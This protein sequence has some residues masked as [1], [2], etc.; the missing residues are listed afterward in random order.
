MIKFLS[1]FELYWAPSESVLGVQGVQGPRDVGH[2]VRQPGDP[3]Q[4]GGGEAAR[5]ELRRNQRRGVVSAGAVAAAR[6][7]AEAHRGG[8]PGQQP[9]DM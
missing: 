2:D 7:D 5:P 6:G 1:T 4:P 8:E 9:R 3:V